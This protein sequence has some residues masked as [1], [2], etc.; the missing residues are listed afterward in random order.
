MSNPFLDNEKT[1]AIIDRH[2][3]GEKTKKDVIGEMWLVPNKEGSPIIVKIN[4]IILSKLGYTSLE[5]EGLPVTDLMTRDETIKVHLEKYFDKAFEEGRNIVMRHHGQGFEI[6]ARDGSPHH[7]A[8]A[9]VFPKEEPTLY[10]KR[11]IPK[12]IERPFVFCCLRI[13]FLDD[14]EGVLKETRTRE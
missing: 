12:E 3:M 14:F 10:G 6:K 1:N 11:M 13:I 5:L 9:A 4:P 8:I 2:L 7:V